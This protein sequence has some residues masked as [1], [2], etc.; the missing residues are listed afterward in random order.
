MQNDIEARM[1]IAKEIAVKAGALAVDMRRNQD[2]SFSQEKSHQDFVTIADLAVE[3][4]IRKQI[5]AYFPQDSILGE[6]EGTT[7]VGDAMWV[8]DPIDGTTNYMRGLADWAVSIA[9]CVG[10]KIECAVIYVLDIDKLVWARAGEGA[11]ANDQKISVSDHAAAKNALVLLGRST[12]CKPEPYLRLLD[13]AFKIGL[14]YRRNGSAA[15][16][17]FL[18]ALGHADAFYE[19]HLNSWD[20]MAGILIVTEAG[21]TVDYPDYNEF[22][23]HG[24][25]VLASNS[26]LHDKVQFI[27]QASTEV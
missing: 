25:A 23:E 7:G 20:A 27:V 12:R 11:L 22:I 16:S 4:L 9:F 17:L 6:E 19:G 8:V 5:W 2:S 13:N 1:Q 21:G 15:Y 10:D 14:E 24:G 26:S 3:S 18:V